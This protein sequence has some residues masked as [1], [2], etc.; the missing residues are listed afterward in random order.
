MEILIQKTSTIGSFVIQQES[1][2]MSSRCGLM[3]TLI[4]VDTN[5]LTKPITAGKA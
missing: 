4:G 2:G 5:G 3:N 1:T